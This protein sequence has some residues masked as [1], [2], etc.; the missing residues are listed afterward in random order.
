M[1]TLTSTEISQDDR[2][3][4][5]SRFCG[6]RRGGPLE[7]LPRLLPFVARAVSST[8]RFTP[9]ACLTARPTQGATDTLT[10][11]PPP[12]FPLRCRR[13]R[14]CVQSLRESRI[15]RTRGIAA[16][17][18]LTGLNGLLSGQRGGVEHTAL[19]AH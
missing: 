15:P 6:T 14:V 19:A 3:D 9:F 5:C 13:R 7:P 2:D 8:R 17:D 16:L 12:L 11:P 1:P 10:T 4:H 18:D